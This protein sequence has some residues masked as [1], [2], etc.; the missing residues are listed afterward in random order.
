MSE[1][2]LDSLITAEL[3]KQGINVQTLIHFAFDSGDLRLWTGIGDL[4]ALSETWTGAG[5]LL[6]ISVVEET[7]EIVSQKVDY[8]LNGVDPSL[9]ALALGESYQGRA[10]EMY[11]AFFDAD[12]ALIDEPISI[13]R[14]LLDV[15]EMKT[16]Q[17]TA[18]IIARSETRLRILRG[19]SNIRYTDAEQQ[20]NYSGDVFFEFVP[21]MQEK[22][23]I[24][25]RK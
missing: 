2:T 15:M 22:N 20:K 9:I 16:D 24:W 3:E 7:S 13:Y 17:T 11:L 10:V 21:A 6:E 8:T 1:R 25:G 14:G 5:S 4:T 18:S 23:L 19:A 12:S